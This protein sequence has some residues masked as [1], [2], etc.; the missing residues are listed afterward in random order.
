MSTTKLVFK[1]STGREVTDAGTELVRLTH[2][3]QAHCPTLSFAACRDLVM[4]AEPEL[5]KA[6]LGTDEE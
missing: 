3:K 5:A 6:W 1:T 2:E 4:R